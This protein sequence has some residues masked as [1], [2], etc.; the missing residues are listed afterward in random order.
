MT[1]TNTYKITGM[2]CMGCV[3]SITRSI[4]GFA[5]E[6]EVNVELE[7]GLVTV[8]SDV[9]EENIIAAAKQSGFTFEGKQA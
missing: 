3:K 5:P 4:K 2:D 6:A 8:S 9:S 7:S 1:A